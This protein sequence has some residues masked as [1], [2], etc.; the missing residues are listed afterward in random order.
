MVVLIVAIIGF[1][2]V[3]LS[4]RVYQQRDRQRDEICALCQ[5]IE[6]LEGKQIIQP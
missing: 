4:F 1:V 2:A 3:T 5:R 6:A